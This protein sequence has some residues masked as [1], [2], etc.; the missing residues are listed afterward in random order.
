MIINAG[1][2][3]NCR[4]P[5]RK[6]ATLARLKLDGTTAGAAPN[7]ASVPGELARGTV[8][9]RYTVLSLVGRGGMS[10]V[11]G[12]YDPEL[13]RKIA[14]KVLH[15]RGAGVPAEHERRLLREARVIA[16]ISHPNVIAVHD[17]GTFGD[18]VFVAIAFVEGTTLRDWL[19]ER[20]RSRDAILAA[21]M[22]AARGLI[23]AH[24]RGVVHRDFK[25]QN[26]LVG[27]DGLVRVTDFGLA[28]WADE[29]P[30][31]ERVGAAAAVRLVGIDLTKT[32][33]IVG[34][35]LYMAPEQVRGEAVD[36][37][38]DQFSF[39]VALYEALTGEHPFFAPDAGVTPAEAITSGRLRPSPPRG[40]VPGWLRR[41]LLRGLSVAPGDR[42][43][44]MD[45]LLSALGRDP[46][47]RRRRWFVAGTV[48]LAGLAGLVAAARSARSPAIACEAGP[49][50]IARLWPT[51][52]DNDS[53]RSR[54]A[55]V[56]AAFLATGLAT[57]TEV[58]EHTAAVVDRYAR[59]WAR[60]SRDNCEATYV[61]RDQA[62]AVFE[63]R[64][65]CLEDR[66]GALE[67]LIDVFA[68]ADAKMM[69][70]AVGA[71]S[72]L[73]GLDLCADLPSLNR[74]PGP[75]DGD[76]RARADALRRRALTARALHDAGR[77]QPA[78]AE[79][80]RLVT[81]ARAL[82]YEPLT[83]ELVE[84]EG[85]FRS[86]IYDPQGPP[87]LEEALWTALRAKRDEVAA[88][89]AALLG[90]IDAYRERPDEAR[91]W[92][93]LAGALVDRLGPGHDR[94][95]SWV[96]NDRAV[97]LESTDP[98]ASLRLFTEVRALKRRILSP[99]DPDIARTLIS[100]AEAFHRAGNDA[101]ALRDADEAVRLLEAA[102]GPNSVMVATAMSNRGEYLVSLGR[103]QEGL[104]TFRDAL[105][106]WQAQVGPD[107]E[108][109]AYP[110]TG[111]GEA[112][113]ALGRLT[114]ARAALERAWRLRK[115]SGRDPVLRGDTEFA[116]ARTM[117][118]EGDRNQA[119][120]LANAA[121]RDYEKRAEVRA[122]RARDVATW[123]AQH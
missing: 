31:D 118:A 33:R 107:D 37:R 6:A 41:V 69:P 27:T 86:V 102:Y 4:S 91:R 2:A 34:T 79:A 105:A 72:A 35:P 62:P 83:A 42:W 48:A 26:V 11:Y 12:A 100:E 5:R 32:G 44:S 116:L 73:P 17:V 99:A 68:T 84:M 45:A 59:E 40:N 60:M 121:R 24:D 112:L 75:R 123:L 1:A 49:A 93:L 52:T 80:T 3:A 97:S 101:A 43:P 78:I 7:E 119:R 10:E 96:L 36:A 92:S 51:R 109:L 89:A 25:P 13:D 71:A 53:P 108:F 15:P 110:L 28:R 58:W 67:A 106:R 56:R 16:Q 61:R 47:R 55:G 81:E 76:V 104:A 8:V 113:L 20:P 50:S 22:D 77:D 23:A 21:F 65:A 39:C 94:L 111:M 29:L 120:D 9:G 19:A 18:R 117:W 90:G 66:R 70:S 57:A 82:G 103:A 122:Q 98:A 46:A 114:E 87:I 63:R 95:R 30:G 38:A 74:D 14:L 54:R 88:D 115:A 64:A 85:Y